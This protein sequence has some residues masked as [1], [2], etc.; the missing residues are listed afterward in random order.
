M[1][2]Q[3]LIGVEQKIVEICLSVYRD[4]QAIYL[5]GSFGTEHERQDS[6]SDIA[7]LFHPTFSVSA[8]KFLLLI[9]KLSDELQKT[10]DLINLQEAG[11]ILQKEI[12]CKGKRIYASNELDVGN[13][14]TFIMRQYQMFT[15]ERKAIVEDGFIKGRFY[16][17]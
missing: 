13:Y 4:L 3:A 5:F 17:T 12:V 8:T 1:K 14:E 2:K 9:S 6:D 15:E 7:I 11:S 10:I 16:G